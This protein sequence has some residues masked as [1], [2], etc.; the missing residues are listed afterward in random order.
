M[1]LSVYV[2]IGNS[3][4]PG[5]LYRIDFT[6]RQRLFRRVLE[7][8]RQLISPER[9]DGVAA[10]AAR[11]V[12]EWNDQRAT[13]RNALDFAFKNSKLGW[14]DQIVRGIDREQR[15]PNFFQVRT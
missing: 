12:A 9:R 11:F 14:I 4:S 2:S 5:V 6:V 15:H 3:H 7:Q 13:V 1:R 10:V 8:D